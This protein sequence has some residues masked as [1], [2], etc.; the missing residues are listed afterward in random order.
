MLL[1]SIDGLTAWLD[2]D[3][4]KLEK[5]TRLDLPQGRHRITFAIE[6]S[7]RQVPLKVELTDEPGSAAKVQIV[8]G[9]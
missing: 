6:L 9:K 5:E 1:N 4:I 7:Q 2:A 8:N 3:P